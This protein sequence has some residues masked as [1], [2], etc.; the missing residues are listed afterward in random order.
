MLLFFSNH[1]KSQFQKS[2]DVDIVVN[3]FGLFA[4]TMKLHTPDEIPIIF[5]I[6]AQKSQEESGKLVP[7][8]TVFSLSAHYQ[9]IL[10]CTLSFNNMCIITK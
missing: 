8:V 5:N 2:E 1:F 9:V 6:L 10:S 7:P 4:K 3:G